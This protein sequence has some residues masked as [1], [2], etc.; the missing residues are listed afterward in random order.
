MNPQV[1][2]TRYVQ[3]DACA[4]EIQESSSSEKISAPSRGLRDGG[5]MAAQCGQGNE[6]RP[7]YISW[8]SCEV[9]ENTES[10]PQSVSD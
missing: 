8:L 1:T 6:W 7:S 9:L 10:F 3:A 2:N 4:W 5:A